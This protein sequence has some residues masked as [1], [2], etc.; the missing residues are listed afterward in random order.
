MLEETKRLLVGAV[1]GRL[2]NVELFIA[3]AYNWFLFFASDSLKERPGAFQLNE[4][5]Y[6]PTYR[7]DL[8][9]EC[10]LDPC[11]DDA[12]S[13]PHNAMGVPVG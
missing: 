4:G 1:S 13:S 10:R 2:R 6:W 3:A 7:A 8:D 12:W 11:V 5:S 9:R